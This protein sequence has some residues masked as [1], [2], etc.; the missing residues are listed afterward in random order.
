MK[1][2]LIIYSSQN[3]STQKIAKKIEA[4]LDRN[5]LQTDMINIDKGGRIPKRDYDF[6]GIGS[7]VYIFRPSYKIMGALDDMGSLSGKPVFTFVTYGA[8]IGDGANWLRR[9]LARKKAVDLGHFQCRGKDLF[10]GY[11]SRGYCFSSESPTTE[12][13]NA[14]EAFGNDV[15]QKVMSKN[16]GAP[17][18]YGDPAHFVYRFERFVTNRLLIRH[19]YSYFFSARKTRCNGCGLC[20]KKCPTQNITMRNKQKPVWGRNCILCCNCQIQCPQ[21]AVNTPIS[22]VLFAPFMWYNILKAKKRVP[23]AGL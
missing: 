9:E 12:E 10:P 23:F 5:G 11:T 18:R 19:F 4:G 20:V 3:G 6:Y 13:Q 16:I 1:A 14:A 21:G 7:P 17:A 2:G 22:W 8:E 15:A